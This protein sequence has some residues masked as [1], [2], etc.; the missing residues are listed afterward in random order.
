M[1]IVY[2]QSSPPT[3]R[4]LSTPLQWHS[5]STLQHTLS[6]AV[7]DAD[8]YKGG[9]NMKNY[10]TCPFFDKPRLQCAFLI[11]GMAMDYALE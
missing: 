1:A 11:N 2:M 8:I 3:S 9:S 7:V 5:N 10:W 6:Y 4:K